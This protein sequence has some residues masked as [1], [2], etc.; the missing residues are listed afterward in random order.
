MRNAQMRD[1]VKDRVNRLGSRACAALESLTDSVRGF[2]DK[3][4][5]DGHREA[6]VHL[7]DLAEDCLAAVDDL[8]DRAEAGDE[9]AIAKLRQA[10]DRSLDL[11]ERKGARS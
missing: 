7:T 3:D 11:G 8:Y 10:A 1:N 2:A 4:V 5:V 6:W 9:D